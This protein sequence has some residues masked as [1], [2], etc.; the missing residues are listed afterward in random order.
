MSGGVCLKTA[1]FTV[2]VDGVRLQNST[3]G[4]QAG[5]SRNRTGSAGTRLDLKVAFV[6]LLP[7]ITCIKKK[8]KRKISI[9]KK[10]GEKPAHCLHEDLV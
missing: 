4:Q 8:K 7:L 1:T 2:Q 5:A 3:A 9:L 6:A 10:R